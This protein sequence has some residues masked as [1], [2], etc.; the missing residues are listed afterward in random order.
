MVCRANAVCDK[1]S[2][3]TEKPAGTFSPSTVYAAEQSRD[4]AMINLLL[5]AKAAS[6]I[7]EVWTT[8][9][10]SR[11]AARHDRILEVGL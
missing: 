3:Q 11:I 10:I 8:E 9:T 5:E 4:K 1:T 6:E 2:P 7:G